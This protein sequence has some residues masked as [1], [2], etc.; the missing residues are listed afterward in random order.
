MKKGWINSKNLKELEKPKGHGKDFNE[1]ISKIEKENGI[2]TKV[3]SKELKDV[4]N[5]KEKEKQ[6]NDEL[7]KHKNELE[8]ARLEKEKLEKELLE[9]KTK[10]K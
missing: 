9:L 8:T 1:T 7:K 4:T 3:D 10:N 6:F 2:N 5:F